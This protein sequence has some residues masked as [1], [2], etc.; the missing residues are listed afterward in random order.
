MRW[1]GLWQAVL[2]TGPGFGPE[3]RWASG[4]VLA[5]P[6]IA[7]LGAALARRYPVAGAWV[8]TLPT[9]AGVLGA[10]AFDVVIGVK[11]VLTRGPNL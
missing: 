11:R 5:V 6:V 4:A 2:R 10:V 3:A 1:I 8:V 9:L 7:G